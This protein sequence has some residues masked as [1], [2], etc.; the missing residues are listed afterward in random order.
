M[1]IYQS[2][3]EINGLGTHFTIQ[4]S[5]NERNVTKRVKKILDVNYRKSQSKKIVTT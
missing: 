5:K 4:D 1:A 2:P 3:Y